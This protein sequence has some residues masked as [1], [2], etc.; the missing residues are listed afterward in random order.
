MN[1]ADV[2][3]VHCSI[4]IGSMT[5]GCTWCN[6]TWGRQTEK[7]KKSLLAIT[8]EDERTFSLGV[9]RSWRRVLPQLC[10]SCLNSIQSVKRKTR[11]WWPLTP[12]TMAAVNNSSFLAHTVMLFTLKINKAHGF[13]G[14]ICSPRVTVGPQGEAKAGVSFHVCTCREMCSVAR[15]RTQRC[16]F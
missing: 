10:C 14:D 3:M 7:E 15:N 11:L 6:Q 16:S 2:L 1:V 5:E 9:L 13:P 8:P 12:Q 4:M